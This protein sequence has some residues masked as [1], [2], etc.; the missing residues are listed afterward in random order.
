MHI[1]CVSRSRLEV[2]RST[3]RELSAVIVLNQRLVSIPSSTTRNDTLYRAVERCLEACDD[4]STAA[5]TMAQIGLLAFTPQLIFHF[6]CAA[7]F[8][9][10]MSYIES[11][12]PRNT[13]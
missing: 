13:Y 10:G 5:I 12:H 4:M 7:R 8:Y 3:D 2:L 11:M 6:F 1:R 9:V